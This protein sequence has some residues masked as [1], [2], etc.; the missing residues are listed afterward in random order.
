MEYDELVDK[1]QNIVQHSLWEV[2]TEHLLLPYDIITNSYLPEVQDEP[3]E[4]LN[5]EFNH[6]ATE[7]FDLG[8]DLKV[9]SISKTNANFISHHSTLNSMKEVQKII[10]INDMKVKTFQRGIYGPHS[11]YLP[12]NR[13][14]LVPSVAEDETSKITMK[15]SYL[16]IGKSLL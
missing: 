7:W 6:F 14:G 12:C 8:F 15:D 3:L 5:E 1:L 9:T 4:R 10:N 13:H 2:V 11:L 16:L